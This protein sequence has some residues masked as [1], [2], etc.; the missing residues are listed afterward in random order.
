MLLALNG[1]LST[2][3]INWSQI[4]RSVSNTL[5]DYKANYK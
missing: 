1:I 2:K 5:V 4:K 3:I